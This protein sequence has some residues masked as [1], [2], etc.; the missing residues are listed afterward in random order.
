[1]RFGFIQQRYPDSKVGLGGNLQDVEN[2]VERMESAV[3][4]QDFSAFE[5]DRRNPINTWNADRLLFAKKNPSMAESLIP[6]PEQYET[7]T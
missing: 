4:A 2:P 3:A 6:Y 5:T 1:M 7:L